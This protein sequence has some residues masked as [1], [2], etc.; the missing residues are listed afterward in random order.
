MAD[1]AAGLI[2]GVGAESATNAPK[3]AARNASLIE[4]C[5]AGAAVDIP[6]TTT[7][8]FGSIEI[9]SEDTLLVTFTVDMVVDDNLSDPANYVMVP[10]DGGVPIVVRDVIIET[11]KSVVT[12]IVLVTT[13]PTTQSEYQLQIKAA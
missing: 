13:V 3:Q 5:L 9:L 11:G 2:S 10:L 1:L 6:T 12:D 7:D 4:L 8:I